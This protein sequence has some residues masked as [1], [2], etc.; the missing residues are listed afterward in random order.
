MP[1][2]FFNDSILLY[3]W[4]LVVW[5]LLRA[6]VHIFCCQKMKYISQC[7]R[8]GVLVLFMDLGLLHRYMFLHLSIIFLFVRSIYLFLWEVLWHLWFS[9]VRDMHI[10]NKTSCLV[11]LTRKIA[12]LVKYL[13]CWPW[14]KQVF[15]WWILVVVI[16]D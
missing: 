8:Q 6:I 12:N 16:M 2:C 13:F 4:F 5:N 10:A 1:F 7:W 3:R 15:V 11:G 14:L 9:V